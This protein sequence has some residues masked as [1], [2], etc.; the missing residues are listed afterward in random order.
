[1]ILLGRGED[2]YCLSLL[3]YELGRRTR[4]FWDPWLHEALNGIG[5]RLDVIT[6]W[7][8]H[9]RRNDIRALT[10]CAMML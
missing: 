1:M 7:V 3:G 6:P 8:L 5:V 10:C 2:A 4:S 9:V